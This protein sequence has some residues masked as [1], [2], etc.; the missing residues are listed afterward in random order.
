MEWIDKNTELPTEKKLVDVLMM[1]DK[2]EVDVTFDPELIGLS[3]FYKYKDEIIPEA[4]TIFLLTHW[5][6]VPKPPK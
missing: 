6:D 1:N 3:Q 5:M 2:R 4:K